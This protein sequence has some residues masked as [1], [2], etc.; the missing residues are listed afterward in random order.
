MFLRGSN[1]N[2]RE[3]VRRGLMYY[4]TNHIVEG[5]KSSSLFTYAQLRIWFAGSVA[6]E[7][8]RPHSICHQGSPAAEVIRL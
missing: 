4:P 2:L 7:R 1:K 3:C 5:S 6:R 8:F